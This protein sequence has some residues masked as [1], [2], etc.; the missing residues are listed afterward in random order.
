MRNGKRDAG[1]NLLELM[2]VVTMVSIVAAIATPMY[3]SYSQRA[4]RSAVEGQMQGLAADLERWRSK[5]LTYAGFVPSMGYEAASTTYGNI[6]VLFPTGSTSTNFRY[7]ILIMDGACRT[8]LSPATPVAGCAGQSWVMV[9]RPNSGTTDQTDTNAAIG[10]MGNASRVVLD[11]RGVRCM[12]S[13][14]FSDHITD[15]TI[16]GSGG[17]LAPT[18]PPTTSDAGLCASGSNTS[19]PWK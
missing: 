17:V 14:T 15:T 19:I 13:G 3:I 10:S 16:F 5:Q 11:S 9:A 6:G 1:F 12:T 2:A 18:I 7:R 4:Q 8:S